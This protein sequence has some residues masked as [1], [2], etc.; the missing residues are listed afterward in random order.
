MF[1]ANLQ[2][3]HPA[4]TIPAPNI[5]KKDLHQSV[6]DLVPAHEHWDQAGGIH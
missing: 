5:S 2:S 1:Y 4:K 6:G 3:S